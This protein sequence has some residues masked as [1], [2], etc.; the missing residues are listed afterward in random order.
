MAGY[1]TVWTKA[2]S[3]TAI[4]NANSQTG[5]D[6]QGCADYKA[7]MDEEFMSLWA[8]RAELGLHGENCIAAEHSAEYMDCY[9]QNT[10]MF[11][12]KGEQ[13]EQPMPDEQADGQAEGSCKQDEPTIPQKHVQLNLYNANQ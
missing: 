4:H 7:K 1:E 13:T 6:V 10:I 3:P 5:K 8:A 11:I 12:G 9:G 2:T